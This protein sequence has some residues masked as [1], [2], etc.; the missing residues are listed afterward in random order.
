MLD[1]LIAI[2]LILVGS[3]ALTSRVGKRDRGLFF[4]ALALHVAA[5]WLMVTLTKG[6]FGGGDIFGYHLGGT[7]IAALLD[8]DFSRWSGSVL[9]YTLG[10]EVFL[11]I[12][13]NLAPGSTASTFGLVGWVMWLTRLD[14]IY[15]LAIL[16]SFFALLGQWAVYRVLRSRFPTLPG[17]AVAACALFVPSTTYWASGPNKEA[18]TV[19]GIG[20]LVAGLDVWD[21]AQSRL[22]GVVLLAGGFVFIGLTKPYVLVPFGASVWAYW[23]VSAAKRRDGRLQV[24]PIRFAGAVVL[25]FVTVAVLGEIFPRF[26]YEQVAKEFASLQAYGGHGGSGYWIG[27]PSARTLVEQLAFAPLGFLFALVR[28]TVFEIRNAAM[29]ASALET[30]LCLILL[31]RVVF[32]S[33]FTKP[34]ERV[35]S[36]PNLAAFGVF[37]LMF[38][39]SIGLSTTNLGTLSRYRA[40]MMPF[41]AML[42][43]ALNFRL[44]PRAVTARKFVPV[45]R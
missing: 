28:P 17:V 35:I 9:R 27:D 21:R 16:F 30:T 10:D 4:A 43:V 18:F 45:R 42:L 5:A 3:V 38:G 23:Y 37:V 44:S 33:G 7:Q 39:I 13:A 12:S 6:Y 34:L 41:Y 25:A 36:N 11:P 19:L 14:S 20:L 15:A 32:R 22:K 24:R 2:S 1:V 26:A 31:V 40:P 29:A 8:S